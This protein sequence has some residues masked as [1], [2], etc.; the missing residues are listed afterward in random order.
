MQMYRIKC[1]YFI[2]DPQKIA[3]FGKGFGE[4]QIIYYALYHPKFLQY[5]DFFVNVMVNCGLIIFGIV[6]PNRMAVFMSSLFCKCM[7]IKKL[8]V[9]MLLLACISRIKL[10]MKNVFH[11]YMLKLAAPLKK[12][13]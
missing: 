9:S 5:E 13:L 12:I 3:I 4:G 10:F 7:A 6:C 1:L 8:V 2:N 11:S